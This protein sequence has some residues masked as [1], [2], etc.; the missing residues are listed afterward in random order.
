MKSDLE[1]VGKEF[2]GMRHSPPD[3]FIYHKEVVDKE[4]H[5]GIRKWSFISMYDSKRHHQIC[6]VTSVNH[7]LPRHA[8]HRYSNKQTLERETVR[9]QELRPKSQ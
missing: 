2:W 9:K 4:K 1:E 8:R 6:A 3:A 5:Y 7:S